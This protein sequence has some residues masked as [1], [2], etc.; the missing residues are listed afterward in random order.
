MD[1][2]NN[3]MEKDIKL[4]E[5]V[6]LHGWA[7]KLPNTELEVLVKDIISKE[8]LEK[9]HIGLGDDAAVIIRNDIA[10]VKTVDVFTPIV[11]DPYT[12]GKIAA[13]NSISDVYAMGVLDIIGVLV[14]M[15]IPQNL[16][17]ECAKEMLKG[18]QDFCRDNDTTIIGGHTILNPVPI[19]GGSVSGVGRKEDILTKGGAKEGDTLILTKPL[20]TQSAMAL[21]RVGEEYEDL[22]DITAKEKKE[23]INKAVEL[24]TTSNRTALIAL[25]ELEQENNEKIVNAMTDITGFGILGHSQEMAEQSDVDIEINLLPIIK[26]TDYLSSMFGHQLLKGYGAET[27]GGLF[28]S[29]NPNFANKLVEK[30]RKNGCYAYIVG[31]VLK[32]KS[33]VGKAYLNNNLKILEI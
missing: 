20:G 24:M 17:I 13:C 7:C 29:V 11:D 19:I 28:M 21:S 10:I 3:S 33:N 5:M 14:I 25:R 16:P 2:I 6:E 23:I 9:T 12:Q 1:K 26:K 22:L 4:T 15:G 30:L 31:K 8:D 27:S 18:F 32:S